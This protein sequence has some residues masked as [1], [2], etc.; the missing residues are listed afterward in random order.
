MG[1]VIQ[2][3]ID[4]AIQI[5]LFTLIP[6]I[7]W[8]ITARKNT[9]FLDW[10]GLKRIKDAK[11]H[12][13]FIWILSVSAAFLLVSVFIIYTLKNIETATSEF[14]GLGIKALPA[15][16]IYAIFN[17]ALAEEIVFRGFI[18]KR[19]S[20]RFGFH[21]GN[22]VQSILFGLLH[23]VMFFPLIGAIKTLLI[24]AFTGGIA[25]CMGYINEKKSEGSIIPGWCIHSVA[26][27]FSG[28]CSAFILFS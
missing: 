8:A 4:S 15:I 23:G 1:L 18:L 25:W 11:E 6:F 13:T 28:L 12:K 27:I 16:L 22:I 21:A 19:I 14:L 26:N 10:I 5:V 20:G 3:L 17:T 2:K 24:I 9:T 7:W